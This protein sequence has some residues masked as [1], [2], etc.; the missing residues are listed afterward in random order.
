[1]EVSTPGAENLDGSSSFTSAA[2]A[3]M[4][5]ARLAVFAVGVVGM[6]EAQPPNMDALAERYV[7][8]VLAVGLHD[9]DYVDAYYGPPEWREGVAA[10]QPSL[11]R[12]YSDA[13]AASSSSMRN[14]LRSTT[15]LL[16]STPKPSSTTC[17]P[18]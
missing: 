12:I 2:G 16:R 8:L 10:Q 13:E 5:R 17:S 11:Q 6:A 7:K 3:V 9:A 14:P 18:S 4:R 15:P 1:M